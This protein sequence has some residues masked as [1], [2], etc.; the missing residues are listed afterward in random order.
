MGL[1]ECS[2]IAI[3]TKQTFTCHSEEPVVVQHDYREALEGS[4]LPSRLGYGLS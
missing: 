1:V 4:F 2:V 3:A